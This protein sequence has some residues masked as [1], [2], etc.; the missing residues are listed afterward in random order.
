M[1]QKLCCRCYK[2]SPFT[3][4]LL[5][6]DNY[7]MNKKFSNKYICTYCEGKC[8][9]QHQEIVTT[10]NQ[11]NQKISSMRNVACQKE[12]LLKNGIF[13]QQHILAVKDCE[14]EWCQS[15]CAQCNQNL[16]THFCGKKSRDSDSDYNFSCGRK[17]CDNCKCDCSLF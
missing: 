15:M 11:K 2:I 14:C 13:C 9:H 10:T 4:P 12:T 16:L 3:K 17:L 7:F 1:E 5:Q 8:L 6:T